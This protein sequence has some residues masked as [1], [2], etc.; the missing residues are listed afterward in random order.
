M[1]SLNIVM[2][3]VCAFSLANYLDRP[4]FFIAGAT[5]H[6][7][8]RQQ[9]EADENLHWKWQRRTADERIR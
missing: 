2:G 3:A 5:Y 9:T 6:K 4:V 1:T 8:H 7:K